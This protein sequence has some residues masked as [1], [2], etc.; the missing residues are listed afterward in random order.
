MPVKSLCT[1]SKISQ[2]IKITLR[3]TAISY[4]TWCDVHDYNDVTCLESHNT[5]YNN[6]YIDTV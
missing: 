3:F 6:V 5:V 1:G 2:I 4:K